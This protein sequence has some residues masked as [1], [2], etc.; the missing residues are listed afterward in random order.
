V[1]LMEGE[2]S[3]PIRFL[4]ANFFC[5]DRCRNHVHG[6]RWRARNPKPKRPRAMVQCEVC[7][8]NFAPARA[9]AKTCSPSCRQKAYRERKKDSVTLK[10]KED[11]VSSC[12]VSVTHAEEEAG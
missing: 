9:G 1:H 8:D 5:S 12:L 10:E 11:T 6:A 7:L 4:Q 3:S 2:Y